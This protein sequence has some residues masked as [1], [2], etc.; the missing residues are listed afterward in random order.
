MRAI[1]FTYA[2]ANLAQTMDEVTNDRA[3]VLLTRQKGEPVVVMSLADYNALE[4]TAYL[5]R[6]PANAS[7]LSRSIEKLRAGKASKRDLIEA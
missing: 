3:P 1:N 7:R 6:S 4:E 2:R 5:L